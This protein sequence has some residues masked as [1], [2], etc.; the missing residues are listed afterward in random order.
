MPFGFTSRVTDRLTEHELQE[1]RLLLDKNGLTFEGSPDFTAVAEDGDGHI[2]ATA[3]LN[4][5]VIKMVASDD[6]YRGAGLT[7]S[8]ITELLR[9]AAERS[10]FHLFLYTKPDTSDKF[11]SI[12]FREL[13]RTRETVL[14]ES[15]SPSADDF[16]AKLSAEKFSGTDKIYG[17][18][19]MNCN[20]FTLGHRHP[21]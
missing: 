8:V 13:A 6:E 11:A 4:G 3:S 19:V 5:N 7:G 1:I 12:G 2:A 18:A 17:A 9:V 21:I 14:M 15:G 10:I 16:R 20:P